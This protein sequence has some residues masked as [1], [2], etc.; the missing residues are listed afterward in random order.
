MKALQKCA[1]LCLLGLA[2]LMAGAGP[3]AR[4]ESDPY[5]E[6]LARMSL[7]EKICQL[8]VVEPTSIIK[9]DYLYTRGSATRKALARYP[10]GGLV[11]F[12][13][14]LTHKDALTQ[15]IAYY[16]QVMAEQGAPPLLICADE[17]GGSISRVVRRYGQAEFPSPGAVGQRG[18]E[19]ARQSG[20]DAGSV[21]KGLGFNLNLAP[22]LDLT[23]GTGP[24]GSRTY[25]SRPEQVIPLASAFVA[26]LKE[27]GIAATAKHFPG[28]GS[29]G[30]DTHQGLAASGRS[31]EELLGH[32]LLP[33]AA[34][35][36]QGIPMVMVGHVT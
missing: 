24:L 32:E 19:A 2:L 25:G 5:Q 29:A 6:R 26:A 12:P 36:K 13:R 22:S 9:K 8:F 17:E 30:S 28:I 14:N 27:Q 16:Q 10:V 35:I 7:E 34:L 3:A 4:G 31:L 1:A 23:D 18:L 21:M 11:Y 15:G 33:F 20:L